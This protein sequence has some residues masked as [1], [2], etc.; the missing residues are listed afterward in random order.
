LAIRVV[1]T[2]AGSC[3]TWIRSELMA[4]VAVVQCPAATAAET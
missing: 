4:L 3:A 1:L 2:D